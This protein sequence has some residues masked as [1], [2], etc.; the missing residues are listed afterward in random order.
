MDSK[1][2]TDYEIL[3]RY[4][5]LIPESDGS[6][7]SSLVEKYHESLFKE[8]AICDL[9]HYKTGQIGIRWRTE[10]EVIRGKG[11]KTCASKTCDEKYPLFTY[12]VT[13]NYIEQNVPK[14]ALVKVRVCD[15][16][17]KKLNYKNEHKLLHYKH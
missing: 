1:P 9:S 10:V 8:F 5:Q 11:E 12:Q 3:K 13:F 2:V 4:H 14:R 16:C 15:K 6:W 17:A 7:E